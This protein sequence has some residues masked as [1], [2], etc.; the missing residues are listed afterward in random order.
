[1]RSGQLAGNM[2]F[3]FINTTATR[4]IGRRK[5][6]SVPCPF[7]S[8]QIGLLIV[9]PAAFESCAMGDPGKYQSPQ[10]AL[11]FLPKLFGQRL[12]DTQIVDEVVAR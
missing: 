7:A 3:A 10:R 5:N 2:S 1:M 11:L 12:Q 6:E 9:N 4:P 8:R